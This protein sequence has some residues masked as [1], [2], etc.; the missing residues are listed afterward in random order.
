MHLHW[1][2]Y[3][4]PAGASTATYRLTDETYS[5]DMRVIIAE[6]PGILSRAYRRLFARLP[7]NNRLRS[8]IGVTVRQV[9]ALR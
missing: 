7:R 4:G 2:S 6:V 5:P 9:W 1:P 8:A 3:T